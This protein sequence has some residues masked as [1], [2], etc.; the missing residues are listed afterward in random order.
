MVSYCS[1]E[2]SLLESTKVADTAVTFR[3]TDSGKVSK[4]TPLHSSRCCSFPLNL[5]NQVSLSTFRRKFSHFQIKYGHLKQNLVRKMN[6][7]NVSMET[8]AA[9]AITGACTL[10]TAEVNTSFKPQR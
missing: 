3:G 7:T 2:K 5:Q 8:G 9:R 10:K 1:K 4:E 6:P